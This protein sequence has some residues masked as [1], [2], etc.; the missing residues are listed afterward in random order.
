[1]SPSPVW[2][3]AVAADTPQGWHDTR[4]LSLL[5]CRRKDLATDLSVCLQLGVFEEFVLNLRTPIERTFEQKQPLVRRTMK[6]GPCAASSP[7]GD[8]GGEI[9]K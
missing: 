4:V 1:M 5:E 7:R 2:N 8:A 3:E 9:R 6:T